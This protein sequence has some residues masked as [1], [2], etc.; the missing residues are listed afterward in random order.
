LGIE[1]ADIGVYARLK[2]GVKTANFFEAAHETAL[3][4]EKQG[5][6]IDETKDSGPENL[7]F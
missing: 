5:D 1:I 7:F 2:S 3:I 6:Q 4:W